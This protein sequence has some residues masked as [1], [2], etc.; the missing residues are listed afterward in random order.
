MAEEAEAGYGGAKVKPVGFREKVDSRKQFISNAV[1]GILEIGLG[2]SQ[3]ATQHTL[4]KWVTH[5]HTHTQACQNECTQTHHKTYS[6]V[7]TKTSP[8]IISS[9]VQKSK[10]L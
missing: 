2:L 7:M 3:R 6:I 10:S 4:G 5:R 9:I 8:A 1:M